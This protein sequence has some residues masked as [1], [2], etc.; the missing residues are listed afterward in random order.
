MKLSNNLAFE[1]IIKTYEEQF[2]CAFNNEQLAELRAGYEKSINIEVYADPIVD[3]YTMFEIRR[4]ITDRLNYLSSAK[5][6]ARFAQGIFDG[7]DELQ[8]DELAI[9]LSKGVD[10]EKYAMVSLSYEEMHVIRRGLEMGVDTSELV[11]NG[12]DLHEIYEKLG[13]DNF[14]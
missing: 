10:V 2:D 3:Y 12:H 13:V 11:Y 6:Q 9:G 5:D 8:L 14:L 7:F 1:N 4:E